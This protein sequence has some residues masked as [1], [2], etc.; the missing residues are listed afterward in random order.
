MR[1]RYGDRYIRVHVNGRGEAA[2][3]EGLW[4]L[5]RCLNDEGVQKVQV[6]KQL[7]FV[8]PPETEMGLSQSVFVIPEETKYACVRCGSCCRNARKGCP[9]GHFEEPNTCKNYG[10]RLPDC[11]RFPFRMLNARPF[12]GILMAASYCK[13]LGDG[14]AISLE[15]YKELVGAL[16]SEDPAEAAKSPPLILDI[17]F[18]QYQKKWSFER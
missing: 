3:N 10:G 17:R 11:R 8:F 6:L 2:M 9:L 4:E 16:S 1:F 7:G 18:D 12:K 14:P 15:R 13:G 5:F